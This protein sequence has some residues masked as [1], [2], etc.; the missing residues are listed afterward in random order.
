MRVPDVTGLSRGSAKDTL[1]AEGL[2][3]SVREEPS[4]EPED[5]VISQDPAGGTEVDAG[6]R[7]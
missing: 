3:V 2:K 5:Q 6:A 1:E 4:D 7:G